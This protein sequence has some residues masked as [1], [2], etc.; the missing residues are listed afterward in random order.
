LAGS[1]VDVYVGMTSAGQDKVDDDELAEALRLSVEVTSNALQHPP[2]DSSTVDEMLSG[3]LEQQEQEEEDVISR[4]MEMGFGRIEVVKAMQAAHSDAERAVEYLMT[5]VPN[6][7][8]QA[9][10]GGDIQHANDDSA[11]TSTSASEDEDELAKAIRLS[12][13]TCDVAI[14]SCSSDVNDSDQVIVVAVSY[15]TPRRI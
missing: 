11:M 5:G 8:G 7:Q 2:E 13:E 12:V 14:D 4:I 1:C 6:G 9:W 15:H 3:M 10:E